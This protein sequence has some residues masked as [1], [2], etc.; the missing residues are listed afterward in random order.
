MITENYLSA[1]KKHYNDACRLLDAAR[2]DK[3][4][5]RLLRKTP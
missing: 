5:E 2:Y 1:G 4:L 3:T